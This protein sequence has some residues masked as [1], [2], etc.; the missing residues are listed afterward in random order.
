[1]PYLSSMTPPRPRPAAVSTLLLVGPVGLLLAGLL[2]AC[3][4][5]Q[6][7][8]GSPGGEAPSPKPA[9]EADEP[10]L[11][12]AVTGYRAY[13]VAQ[14]D[15]MLAE[16]SRLAAAAEAGELDRARRLYPVSR[17]PWE[18]IEPIAGLIPDFDAA[19]DARADGG[20][21][22]TDDSFTG[23]HRVEYHLWE[24]RDLQAAS[25]Y[26]DRLAG[27]LAELEEAAP[28]LEITPGVLTVGAQEL[29]EEVAAPDG[30][31]SGE[32]DRYSGTDLYDFK[33]NV[34]GS[35]VLVDLLEPALQEA[36]PALADRIDAQFA[37]LDGRLA[38]F[39]GFAEGFADYAEVSDA[40][41]AE[42]SATLGAL[43]ES[44]SQLNGALGLA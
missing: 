17:R 18:R 39:G 24:D 5:E 20:T 7:S 31:L 35:E 37:E 44:L 16:T 25:A 40:E 33:A 21:G 22:P 15:T 13:V 12:E 10:L 14:I 23:W 29:I 6:A 19:V 28:G 43:A 26:A 32:E 2:T 42:L 4:S 3:G 27:D 36:D 30:K 38:A 34:E 11:D 41:R 1:M 8:S 9:T